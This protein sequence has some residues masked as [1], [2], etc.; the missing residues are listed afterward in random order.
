M[1]L[2]I[3]VVVSA[4]IIYGVIWWVFRMPGE[5]V[6]DSAAAPILAF[7][8]VWVGLLS[9]VV[10]GWLWV[11][12][13]EDVWV[14]VHVVIWSIAITMAAFSLWIYRHTPGEQ[15]TEPIQMQRAQARVGLILGL[16]GVV[17]WYVFVVTHKQ[18]FTPIGE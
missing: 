10:G 2:T 18:V 6:V 5:A 9:V 17:L 4:G 3:Q 7:C 15:M 13:K 14:P 8:S 12:S 1:R 16:V 11:T